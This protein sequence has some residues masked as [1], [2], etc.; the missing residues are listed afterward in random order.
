MSDILTAIAALRR[1]RLL[2]RA[3]KLGVSHYRGER[4]LRRLLGASTQLKLEERLTALYQAE[5]QAETT[6]REGHAAYD[7]SRHL[8][9]LIAL[10]AEMRLARPVQSG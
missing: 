8:G 1:P 7:A 9:L 5:A 3:A 6:R 2:I 4:D 10:I